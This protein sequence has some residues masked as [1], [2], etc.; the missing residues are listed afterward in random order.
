ME[1]LDRSLLNGIQ[2]EFPLCHAPFRTLAEK[3]GIAEEEVLRRI[4]RLKECGLIREIAAVFDARSLGYRSSLIAMK[5][6]PSRIEEAARIVGEHPGVSHNYER[7]D[8]FNLWFTLAVPPQGSLERTVE[9]LHRASG[10]LKTLDLP[11]QKVYK[12]GV[13]FRFGEDGAVSE[14]VGSSA[15]GEARTSPSLT[16]ADIKFTRAF[17]EELSICPYPYEVLARRAGL[18]EK[19]FLEKAGEFLAKG[20]IRR[21]GALIDHRK[22]GFSANLMVAWQVPE[23]RQDE[24]GEK[25]A[26]F[27]EISHCY[28]RKTPKEWSYPIFSMIHMA[29]VG[30][31]DELMAKI[32]SKVGNCNKISILGLREFKKVRV[33]YFCE[34]PE[35]AV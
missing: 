3:L 19:T 30:N 34:N 18:S 12:I 32:C 8:E 1:G 17:Q 14:S 9:E 10:S 15:P 28:K 22:A 24:I 27:P 5:I 23:E 13:R 20:Y 16:D 31:N 2:G 35:K 33:R 29:K 21:V 11:V 26:L 25:L 6:V 7:A 4:E